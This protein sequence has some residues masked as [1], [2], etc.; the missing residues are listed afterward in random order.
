[1]RFV[2]LAPPGSFDRPPSPPFS[3]EENKQNPSK[4]EEKRSDG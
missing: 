2:H 1:M 4:R 3:A